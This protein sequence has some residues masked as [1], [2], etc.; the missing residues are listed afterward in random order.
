MKRDCV[1]LLLQLLWWSCGNS[2]SRGK[3]MKGSVGTRC[4]AFFCNKTQALQLLQPSLRYKGG[5]GLICAY[6][7]R[8]VLQSCGSKVKDILRTEPQMCENGLGML[9]DEIRG[10]VCPT[11]SW[12]GVVTQGLPQAMLDAAGGFAHGKC[13]VWKPGDA[14]KQCCAMARPLP[15]PWGAGERGALLYPSLLPTPKSEPCMG[16]AV[17]FAHYRSSWQLP[18]TLSACSCPP[19]LLLAAPQHQQPLV[20]GDV[21][22]G[23][24]LWGCLSHL[25]KPSKQRNVVLASHL[26][27]LGFLFRPLCL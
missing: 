14:A 26:I 18:A 20:L 5:E 3:K 10:V 2:G 17:W 24:H 11:P 27:C 6:W 1:C 9:W 8:A 13:P 12:R 22:P 15:L 16:E 19:F 21:T 25:L 23:Q 4:F 7:E